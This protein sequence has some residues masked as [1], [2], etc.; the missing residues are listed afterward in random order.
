MARYVA[1][2]RS[3]TLGLLARGLAPVD[4]DLKFGGV[5]WALVE[6][7]PFGGRFYDSF[8]FAR[9]W[10]QIVNVKPTFHKGLVKVMF[11]LI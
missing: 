5:F 1:P 6:G 2:G 7:T 4:V 9:F 3:L 10:L 11:V 8:A